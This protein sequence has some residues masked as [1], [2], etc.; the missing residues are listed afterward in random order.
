MATEEQ[1]YLGKLLLNRV[2]EFGVFIGLSGEEAY[3]SALEAYKYLSSKG[4]VPE[5]I[6]EDVLSRYAKERTA[7]ESIRAA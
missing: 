7:A 6:T 2:V 3:K 4:K 5:N 1:Y